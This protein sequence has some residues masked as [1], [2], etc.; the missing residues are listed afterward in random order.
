MK[1]EDTELYKLGELYEYFGN[2][3]KDPCTSIKDLARFAHDNNFH[4]AFKFVP[5]DPEEGTSNE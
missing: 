1:Y 5:A 4:I 2:M 3:L